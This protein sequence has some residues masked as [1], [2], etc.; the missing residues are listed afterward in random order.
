MIPY[1]NVPSD[2]LV[3]KSQTLVQSLPCVFLAPPAY[4]LGGSAKGLLL[5]PVF[6]GLCV[7]GGGGPGGG[8]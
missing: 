2:W 7:A 4:S 3:A 1:L 8:A 5:E 6:V